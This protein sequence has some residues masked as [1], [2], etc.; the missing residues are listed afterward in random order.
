MI[1]CRCGSTDLDVNLDSGGFIPRY[2]C[3]CRNCNRV[4][5]LARW[6]VDALTGGHHG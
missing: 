5:H 4:W 1:H 3:Y 2:L 6:V